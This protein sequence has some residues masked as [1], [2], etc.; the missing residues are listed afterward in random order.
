MQEES[1]P[2]TPMV[3]EAAVTAEAAGAQTVK[4][5]WAV[6][7]VEQEVTRGNAGGIG[8]GYLGFNQ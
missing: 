5:E 8:Y 6:A 3:T 2:V 7:K 4:V 1:A